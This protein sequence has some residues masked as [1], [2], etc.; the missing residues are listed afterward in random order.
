MGLQDDAFGKLTVRSAQVRTAVAI[1][2]DG[3]LDGDRFAKLGGLERQS[4]EF[5]GDDSGLVRKRGYFSPQVS[6]SAP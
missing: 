5:F 1:C 4:N 6:R 2:R 3:C